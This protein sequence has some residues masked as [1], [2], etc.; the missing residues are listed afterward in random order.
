MI[1][2]LC[3]LGRVT[4]LLGAVTFCFVRPASGQAATSLFGQAGLLRDD[5]GNWDV[6]YSASALFPLTQDL[7]VEV[8]VQTVRTERR[9]E[10]V[11]LTEL[12]HA[13]YTVVGAGIV[14]E[15]PA[16]D[17]VR[18]VAGGGAGV[19]RYLAKLQTE[20][21][22]GFTPQTSFRSMEGTIAEVHIEVGAIVQAG[23]HFL[24]RAD[25]FF[26]VGMG[27]VDHSEQCTGCFFFPARQPYSSF[28]LL[29]MPGFRIG[30]GYKF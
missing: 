10:V 17:R 25:G 15:V 30:A 16:A 19:M 12:R 28:A 22:G 27:S 5:W 13:S 8:C 29:L 2:G 20:G 24:V 21:S 23:R 11:T 7:R 9:S 1:R 18:F 26:S 3:T 14:V 6:A 4:V